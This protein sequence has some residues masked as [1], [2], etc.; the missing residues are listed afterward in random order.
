MFV[1]G[2]EERE[3]VKEINY[4]YLCGYYNILYKLNRLLLMIMMNRIRIK[5]WRKRERRRDRIV[6]HDKNIV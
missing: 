6:L 3:E 2:K 4:T 1:L 5:K